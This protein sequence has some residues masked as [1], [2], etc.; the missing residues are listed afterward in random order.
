MLLSMFSSTFCHLRIFFGE[1]SIQIIFTFLKIELF[2]FLLSLDL[3]SKHSFA[4]DI[5]LCQS[6]LGPGLGIVLSGSS[7]LNCQVTLA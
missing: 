2:V 1:V 7:P 5:R 3:I 6:L 4:N